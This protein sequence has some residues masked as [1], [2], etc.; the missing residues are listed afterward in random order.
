MLEKPK[1]RSVMKGSSERIDAAKVSKFAI[2]N[3]FTVIGHVAIWQQRP[4]RFCWLWSSYPPSPGFCI[5]CYRHAATG[6]SRICFVHFCQGFCNIQREPSIHYCHVE[7]PK[8]ILLYHF[9][10]RWSIRYNAR[11]ILA[12]STP[13]MYLLYSFTIG[14]Q[15][16]STKAFSFLFY[17]F[18]L[19]TGCVQTGAD[20]EGTPTSPF[21]LFLRFQWRVLQS[22]STNRSDGRG[23]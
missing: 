17:R 2:L 20:V 5:C 22:V 3:D 1:T 14:G 21:Q 15:D 23:G 11:N 9:L 19:H 16:T 4:L 7:C 10:L 18:I 13:P 12:K 8:K 6:F